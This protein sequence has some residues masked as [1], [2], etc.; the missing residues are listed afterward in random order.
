MTERWTNKVRPSDNP[1]NRFA[2]GPE[3][4]A[5]EASERV[6]RYARAQDEETFFV[7]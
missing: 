4:F 1:A 7:P 5:R 3:G 6:V 2:V